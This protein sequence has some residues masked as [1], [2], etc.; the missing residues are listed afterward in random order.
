MRVSI[1]KVINMSRHKDSIDDK[2]LRGTVRKDREQVAVADPGKPI[3][4]VR[5]AY[6]VSGYAELSNRAKALYRQKCKELVAGPGLF[7]SDLHQVVLYAHSY[8]QYWIYDDSVKEHGAVLSNANKF[9]EQVLV[10][11][12]AVKMRRDALKDLTAIAARF[13][14]SP[15]DRAK[16][17]FE[18]KDSEDPLDKFMEE[19]G[20]Q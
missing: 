2:K 10:A 16:I 6:H 14:F 8:D 15:V 19:F 11:N 9:G 1:Q 20:K 17:K 13:G 7:S 18:V 12:P 5:C 3:T 4:D